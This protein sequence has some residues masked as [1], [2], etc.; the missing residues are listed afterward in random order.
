[1]KMIN[2]LDCTLREA[3][4]KDLVYGEFFLSRYIAG[5]EKT[6]VDFIELGFLKDV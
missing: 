1:M 5:L 2:L 3:P 6:R 4:I